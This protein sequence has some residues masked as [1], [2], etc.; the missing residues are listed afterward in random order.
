MILTFTGDIS[1]TGSFTQK[2]LSNSEIFSDDILLDL[3]KS[4]TLL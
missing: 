4:L 2:V 1:I 3:K